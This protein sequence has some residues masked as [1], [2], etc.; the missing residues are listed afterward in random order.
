LTLYNLSYWIK[1]LNKIR[2]NRRKHDVTRYLSIYS[3]TAFSWALV[4]FQFLNLY[5]ICRTPWIGDQSIAR[6]LPIHR[7]NAYRHLC[8][9]WDSKPRFQF[10]ERVKTV[11]ALDR[12]AAVIGCNVYIE[13]KLSWINEELSRHCNRRT[14]RRVNK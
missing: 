14:A 4:A 6:P 12:A 1:S 2:I 7:I 9:E 3:S 5:I 13:R 8:L 11:H 10:S